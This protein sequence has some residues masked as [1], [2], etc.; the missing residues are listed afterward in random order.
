[1]GWLGGLPGMGGRSGVKKFSK[2]FTSEKS[3][4]C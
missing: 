4:R 2:I 1:M 3:L